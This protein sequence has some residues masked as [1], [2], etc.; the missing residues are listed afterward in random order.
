VPFVG[1]IHSFMDHQSDR[2]PRDEALGKPLGYVQTKSAVGT[3][4]PAVPG[5]SPLKVIARS[6]ILLGK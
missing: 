2:R 1:L 3:P 5:S 4:P 6:V